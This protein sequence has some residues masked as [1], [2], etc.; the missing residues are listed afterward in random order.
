MYVGWLYLICGWWDPQNLVAN[1]YLRSWREPC[2][3]STVPRYCHILWGFEL[4]DVMSLGC[5]S[6][7][8]CLLDKDGSWTSFFAFS[9]HNESFFKALPFLAFTGSSLD[10]RTLLS[11]W[12]KLLLGF[13]IS[14]FCF[15]DGWSSDDATDSWDWVST[16]SWSAAVMFCLQNKSVYAS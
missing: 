6:W 11:P 3:S 16:F 14:V 15:W 5:C 8:G 12:D 4:F 13:A 9:S 7:E 1:N 2:C 10:G